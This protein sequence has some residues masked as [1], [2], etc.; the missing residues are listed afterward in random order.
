MGPGYETK[1]QGGTDLAP[2]V[3]PTTL[4]FGNASQAHSNGDRADQMWE[5][6]RAEL[7]AQWNAFSFDV[8]WATVAALELDARILAGYMP[9][10]AVIFQ[11][12][13]RAIIEQHNRRFEEAEANSPLM[14]YWEEVDGMATTAESRIDTQK[15]RF[16]HYI[17]QGGNSFWG[18]AETLYSEWLGGVE[19]PELSLYSNAQR[20]IGRL[21]AHVSNADSNTTDAV[22]RTLA[23]TEH[24]VNRWIDAMNS[25]INARDEGG[26]QAVQ[27]LTWTRDGA[28]TALGALATGGVSSAVGAQTVG[29]KMLVSG[30]VAGGTSATK[31]TVIQGAEIQAG[32]RSE[33]DVAA[34]ARSAAISGVG[35]FL[36]SGLG[37][38]ALGDLAKWVKQDSA[39]YLIKN[40]G[41][42][43]S[44]SV[45]RQSAAVLSVMVKDMFTGALKPLMV[46]FLKAC[47]D[48]E[49]V[50]PEEFIEKMKVRMGSKI[51]TN[52]ALAAGGLHR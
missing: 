6:R 32:L 19:L 40:F 42:H 36:A 48:D 22:Q 10:P 44:E 51:L 4:S 39:E 14:T 12:N 52:L 16:D 15:D 27:Q 50:T 26:A 9:H 49:N 37:S 21:R 31:Q 38:W 43:V 34:I 29:A 8:Q 2:D 28:F 3:E 35:S 17:Q 41:A 11:M 45:C 25:Y 23:T 1:E 18:G 46:E 20:C 33:W 7:T 24:H 47:G 30:V 13:E 5:A